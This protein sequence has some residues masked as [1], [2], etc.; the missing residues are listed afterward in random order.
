M[1]DVLRQLALRDGRFSPEAF[2]FLFDS[3]D[4]AIRLAGKEAAVGT[5]RHVSGS[6]V[7]QGLRQHALDSFGPLAATVWRSWGVREA[8]DWGRIVF[9][10]VEEGHLKRQEGDRIEDFDQPF[11]FDQTFVASYVPALPGELET[12]RSE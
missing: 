7:L 12:G 5:E 4:T 8:M 1:K 6:E 2:H 11:D 9:L 10:L 3:L